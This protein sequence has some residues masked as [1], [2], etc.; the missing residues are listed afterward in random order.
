[1]LPFRSP[2]HAKIFV[3]DP[4]T[5]MEKSPKIQGNQGAKADFLRIKKLLE[6]TL[7][8]ELHMKRLK[9]ITIT[10]IIKTLNGWKKIPSWYIAASAVENKKL[11]VQIPVPIIIPTCHGRFDNICWVF[12][13][14]LDHCLRP[15]TLMCRACVIATLSLGLRTTL[16]ARNYHTSSRTINTQKENL[17]NIEPSWPHDIC[18]AL[19]QKNNNNK[20]EKYSS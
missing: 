16:V 8:N 3:K 1:M 18:R 19:F 14:L 12:F 15:Y 4:A 10:L 13:S 5:F 6:N 11:V 9:A 20:I 7:T 2:S 17:A